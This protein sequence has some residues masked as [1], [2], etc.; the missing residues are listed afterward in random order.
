MAADVY[1]SVWANFFC[2]TVPLSTW[3]RGLLCVLLLFISSSMGCILYEIGNKKKRKPRYKEEKK[4]SFV[5]WYLFLVL[6]LVSIFILITN[7][8][9]PP[10]WTLFFC[11]CVGGWGEDVGDSFHYCIFHLAFIGIL[12]VQLL[13]L[14]FLLKFWIIIEWAAL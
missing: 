14:L 2:C 12:I 4:C 8:E 13:I 1:C 6:F 5:C 3:F 9:L 10:Q 11:V 7:S